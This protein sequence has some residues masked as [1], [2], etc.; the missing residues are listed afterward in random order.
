MPSLLAALENSPALLRCVADL[1]EHSPYLAEHLIRHPEDLALVRSVADPASGDEAAAKRSA[2]SQATGTQ[3]LDK[4]EDV[5]E[6][7]SNEDNLEEKSDWLRRL[8]RREMLRIL[9]E[10][11]HRR[12]AIFATLAET[13]LLTTL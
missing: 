11:I 7:L 6:F 8:Y 1:V 9:T 2:S 10:S 4:R 3:P 13:S 5:R 12:Q